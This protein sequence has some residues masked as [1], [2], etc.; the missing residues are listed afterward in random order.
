[1]SLTSAP[2]PIPQLAPR[3]LLKIQCGAGGERDPLDGAL[4]LVSSGSGRKASEEILSVAL[5]APDD[6]CPR[7]W[8]LCAEVGQEALPK[9]SLL[10]I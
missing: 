9:Q 6:G 2:R 7:V 4:L 8:G 5:R 10:V 1:M 3:P